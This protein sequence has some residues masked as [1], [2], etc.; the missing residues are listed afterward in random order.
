[1]PRIPLHRRFSSA[2]SISRRTPAMPVATPFLPGPSIFAYHQPPT[3]ENLFA[4][5]PPLHFLFWA[6]AAAN[7]NPAKSYIFDQV[8]HLSKKVP[9]KNPPVFFILVPADAKQF[10]SVVT[11]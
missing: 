5:P 3:D 1:M 6:P 10:P 7:K 2:L 8:I 9:K 11:D 4:P